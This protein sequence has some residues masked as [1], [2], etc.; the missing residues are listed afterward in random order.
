[1]ATRVP[2]IELRDPLPPEGVPV[3]LLASF[4]GLAGVPLLALAK[5]NLSA[6]LRLYPDRVETKVFRTLERPYSAIRRVGT[7]TT[8]ATRNVELVWRGS[9]VSFTANIRNDAWRLA[10]LR[11]LD[12]RGVS[13]TPAARSLL[14]DSG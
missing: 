1:M 3:P 13:M 6:R 12:G 2:E 8:L 9:V 11:F 10:L 14:R 7:Q 5:N 4:L